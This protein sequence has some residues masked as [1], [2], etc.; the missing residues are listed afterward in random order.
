MVNS[1]NQAGFLLSSLSR[2]SALF[3]SVMECHGWW[4]GESYSLAGFGACPG[5]GHGSGGDAALYPA[6]TGGIT[7]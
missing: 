3:A 4:G 1:V 5:D 2:A 7:E 6:L